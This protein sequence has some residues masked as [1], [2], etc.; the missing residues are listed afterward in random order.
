MPKEVITIKAN[1]G[2]DKSFKDNH[3]EREKDTNEL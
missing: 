1:P 2:N 3:I